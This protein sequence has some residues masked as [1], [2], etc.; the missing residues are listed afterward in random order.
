MKSWKVGMSLE[1]PV[2]STLTNMGSEV[3]L[4]LVK[5][6]HKLLCE[7]VDWFKVSQKITSD[8]CLELAM[9]IID[10]YKTMSLEDFMLFTQ[11][12]KRGKFKEDKTYNRVDAE[13]IQGWLTKWDEAIDQARVN[14]HSSMKKMTTD[15]TSDRMGDIYAKFKEGGG[16]KD[17]VKQDREKKAEFSRYKNEYLQ[18]RNKIYDDRERGASK[19]MENLI[20]K[21]TKNDEK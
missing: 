18:A 5:A 8:E 4:D 12:V 10:Q 19:R 16:L 11:A 3:R 17:K 21:N 13:V 15:F 2:F 9:I 14:N 1:R 7:V 6:V 20:S